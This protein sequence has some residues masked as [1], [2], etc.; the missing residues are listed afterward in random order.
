MPVLLVT[1][2]RHQT[3]GLRPG[4]EDAI[5]HCTCLPREREAPLCSIAELLPVLQVKP[6]LQ[7]FPKLSCPSEPSFKK[8]TEILVIYMASLILI[9]KHST[10]K[11]SHLLKKKDS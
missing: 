10:K 6:A 3:G 11:K 8:G 5:S 2:G 9:I 1:P 4:A 7:V